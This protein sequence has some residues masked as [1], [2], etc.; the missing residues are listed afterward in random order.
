MTEKKQTAAMLATTFWAMVN[1]FDALTE[2]AKLDTWIRM[3]D[4]AQ[5]YNK[6]RSSEPTIYTSMQSW[7]QQLLP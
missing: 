1:N 4:I 3:H 6:R 7:L 5:E 2:T